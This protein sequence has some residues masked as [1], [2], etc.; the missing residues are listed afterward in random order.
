MTMQFRWLK[1]AMLKDK[2]RKKE[3]GLFKMIESVYKNYKV[4][5]LFI[6]LN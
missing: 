4:L 3:I 5:Y 6:N 1:N 2:K